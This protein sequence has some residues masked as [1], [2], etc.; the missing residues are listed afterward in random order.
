MPLNSLEGAVSGASLCPPGGRCG[1]KFIIPPQRVGSGD[2]FCSLGRGGGGGICL[3]TLRR[4]AFHGDFVLSI[5]GGDKISLPLGGGGG[6]GDSG[7]L[8]IFV[9]G[10]DETTTWSSK[11]GEGGIATSF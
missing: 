5:E 11:R 4:G 9:K 7:I 6:G 1:G 2:P 8:S 3:V 10:G